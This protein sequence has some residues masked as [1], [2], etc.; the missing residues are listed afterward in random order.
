MLPPDEELRLW[1]L[2]K[3]DDWQA[4]TT[5]YNYYFKLLNNYGHKFT[6]DVALIADAVQDLFIKLWTTRQSLGNPL[7]V[8]NYLFKAL[9]SI[10]FRK[11]HVRSRF[12]SV[13][14]GAEA[15]PFEVSFDQA[16]IEDEEERALQHK[17]KAVISTLPARQQE[18]V[19]LR[20]YEGFS[21]PEI[22]DIMDITVASTYKLL[23]KALHK[24]E[25]L[26]KGSSALG[27][28]LFGE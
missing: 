26:F 11:L 17:M 6:R 28:T 2:F 8:K 3:Q 25:E 13:D 27:G 23:Y 4:Y 22:A 21:Y 20:F 24:L 10:I 7:S 1:N 12:T 19:F 15:F 5:L 14:E 16:V 9:R 18:I